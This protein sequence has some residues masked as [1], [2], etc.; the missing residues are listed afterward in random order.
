L[1]HYRWTKLVLDGVGRS[2]REREREVSR[3]MR[4]ERDRRNQELGNKQN[5]NGKGKAN[6]DKDGGELDF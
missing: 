2:E 4:R 6:G 5:W 1:R 3:V